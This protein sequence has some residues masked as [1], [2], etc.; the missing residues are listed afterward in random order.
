MFFDSLLR[1]RDE[2]HLTL[3]TA[4]GPERQW[5]H[6]DT[7]QFETIIKARVPQ[8]KYRSG[9]VKELAVLWCIKENLQ[10]SG[11]IAIPHRHS[12]TSKR[13]RPVQCEVDWSRSRKWCVCCVG[14]CRA[15]S[16]MLAITSV[17]L[18]PRDSILRYKRS[19]PTHAAFAASRTIA[20]AFCHTAES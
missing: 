6:L 7:C 11:T 19:K 9:K 17:M 15:C 2:K 18:P 5:R 1:S 8:L 12:T 14:T 13:G 3:R 20:S 16:T 10:N 4:V